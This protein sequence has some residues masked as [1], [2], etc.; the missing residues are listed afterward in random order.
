MNNKL[1]VFTKPWKDIALDKLADLVKSLGFDGV[2]LPVRDGFQVTPDNI[3]IMLPKA[4]EIFEGRGL[5][6][7]SVAGSLDRTTIEAMGASGI[8]LLRVCIPVDIQKGYFNSVDEYRKKVL[9]LREI[10]EKNAVKVGM[11]NH[12]GYMVQTALGLR[13]LLEGIPKEIAGSVIDFGHCGLAGEPVDM[14]LDIAGGTLLMANFKSAY[15][16]RINDLDSLEGEYQVVWCSSQFGL[17][18][19][20][21][22]LLELRKRKYTGYLC[23]PAE[24]NHVG[25]NTPLVGDDV[26]ERVVRDVKTIRSLMKS[27]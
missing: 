12:H 14:A 3:D 13:N 7:G 8:S 10:L 23:L 5:V 6:I 26:S 1:L 9:S 4:K 15:R 2:E 25:D 24:Y 22:A 19:W 27:L 21:N 20:E 11:Q 17:Y 16:A 18:S